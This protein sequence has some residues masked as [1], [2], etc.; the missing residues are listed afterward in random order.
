[1]NESELDM[2]MQAMESE[3]KD[4][5]A[6]HEK[7]ASEAAEKSGTDSKS[8]TDKEAAKDDAEGTNEKETQENKLVQDVKRLAQ[9]ILHPSNP[10]TPNHWRNDVQ[11]W[12][13]DVLH[14]EQNRALETSMAAADALAV[15]KATNAVK[16]MKTKKAMKAKAAAPPAAMKAMK[17]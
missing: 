9:E 13:H 16:A 5:Q 8:I 7:F 11:M 10:L 6:D 2:E 4:A 12:Y 15:P 1:M 17:K 14:D 3:E